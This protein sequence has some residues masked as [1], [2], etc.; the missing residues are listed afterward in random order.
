MTKE[1]HQPFLPESGP[2]PAHDSSPETLEYY[3]KE[4]YHRV[5][6]LLQSLQIPQSLLLGRLLLS[7]DAVEELRQE[8]EKMGKDEL[9]FVELEFPDGI[10]FLR[11]CHTRNAVPKLKIYPPLPGN[12]AVDG[13]NEAVKSW[14]K[15]MPGRKPEPEEPL[16]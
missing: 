9:Q 15:V 14:D 12:A 7:S 10:L 16:G 5:D 6:V 11:E 13:F 2:Q 4:G 1:P 8:F 3:I